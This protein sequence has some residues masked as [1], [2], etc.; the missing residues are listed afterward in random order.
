MSRTTPA[1]P[2]GLPP[3]RL[4]DPIVKALVELLVDGGLGPGELLPVEPELGEAYGVSRT[5]VREAI[6]TMEALRMVSVHQGRGTAARPVE[7]WDLA[8][9][10]VLSALL[11]HDDGL[12]VVEDLVAVRATLEGELAATA[13]QRATPAHRLRLLDRLAD[14][15]A[16]LPDP[17]TYAAADLAF[18]DVILSASGNRLGRTIVHNLNIE[19]YRS[20]RYLGQP[21]A[22]HVALTHAEHERIHGAVFAGDPAG[23]REAMTAH[24]HQ[25]WERR[26]PR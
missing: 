4:A 10:V 14:L 6:K 22:A 15:H 25:S 24:I 26:R 1:R 20:A 5:V 2:R 3:R 11:R 8:H 19:A 23:A 21:D 13:A 7:D 9:P 17:D 18:H 12:A 16:A